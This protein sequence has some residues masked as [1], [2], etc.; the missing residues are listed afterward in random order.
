MMNINNRILMEALESR[1]RDDQLAMASPPTPDP[2]QPLDPNELA[3]HE[4]LVE[5][6]AD[7]HSDYPDHEIFFG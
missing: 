6:A 2:G 3:L 4:T 1:T 7:L 5:I